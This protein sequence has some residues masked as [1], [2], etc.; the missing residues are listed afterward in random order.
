[1]DAALQAES[2]AQSRAADAA[3]RLSYAEADR[4][5]AVAETERDKM[6]AVVSRM[7]IR[8][9]RER[10]YAAVA[11]HQ[12]VQAGEDALND[13]VVLAEE[14]KKA[15]DLELAQER[16]RAGVVAEHYRRQDRDAVS[17]TALNRELEARLGEKEAR[18]EEQTQMLRATEA[19]EREALAR[20]RGLEARHDIAKLLANFRV[21]DLKALAETQSGVTRAINETLLPALAQAIPAL[22]S[23]SPASAQPPAPAPGSAVPAAAAP[24]PVA[25]PAPAL[26]AVLLPPVALL[27][28]TSTTY[29]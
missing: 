22:V 14:V 25:A 4:D 3:K 10:M 16:Q 7:V 17:M 11:A 6:V 8:K 21:D 12:R 13:R 18:L 29:A 20:L 19:R 26:A 23:G 2:R 27:P 1:M 5:A 15:I 28:I 24:A 9:T